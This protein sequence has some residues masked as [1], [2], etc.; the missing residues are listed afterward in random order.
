[1]EELTY[2]KAERELEQILDD[3]RNDRISID[4]LAEKVERASKLIVF[5]KERLANT[6]KKVE[7]IIKELGL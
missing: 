3:L 1:M 7:N 6:E 2:E 4:A 5:C